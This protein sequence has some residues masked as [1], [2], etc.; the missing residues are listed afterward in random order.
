MRSP[1]AFAFALTI[2]RCGCRSARC[3]TP[4]RRALSGFGL[5]GVLYEYVPGFNGVRVPARYA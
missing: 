2:L 1:I 5:Y 4:V 3:R